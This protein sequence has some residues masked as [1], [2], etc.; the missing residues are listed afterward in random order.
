MGLALWRRLDRP[1]SPAPDESSATN[2]IPRVLAGACG[3]TE[4]GQ[5]VTSAAAP[6]IRQNQGGGGLAWPQRVLRPVASSFSPSDRNSPVGETW[7]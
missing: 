6:E 5:T 1:G 3:V 2:A 4:A 7:R